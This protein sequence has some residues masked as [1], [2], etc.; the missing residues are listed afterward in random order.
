[1]TL[2][3]AVAVSSLGQ[4]TGWH[5]SSPVIL[6]CHGAKGEK[7]KKDVGQI[8]IV[9]GNVSY[10]KSTEGRRKWADGGGVVVRQAY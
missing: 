4:V 10:E 7:R 5:R 2:F 8:K 3:A 1:V 9:R 6:V